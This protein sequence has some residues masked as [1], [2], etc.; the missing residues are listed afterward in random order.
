MFKIVLVCALVALVAANEVAAAKQ[1]VKGSAASATGDVDGNIVGVYSLTSQDG[2]QVLLTYAADEN[3]F[4]SN[5]LP[6]PHPTPEAIARP[7]E[8]LESHPSAP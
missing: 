8:W 6:T 7:L 3:G 4:Q 2:E 1:L 5:R